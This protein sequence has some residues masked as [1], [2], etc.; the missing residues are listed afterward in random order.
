VFSLD[1]L[2]VRSV[3]QVFLAPPSSLSIFGHLGE[4]LEKHGCARDL[5]SRAEFSLRDLPVDVKPVEAEIAANLEKRKVI[6]GLT[7]GTI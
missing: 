6:T 3:V 1:P 4:S 5:V 7:L 2:G